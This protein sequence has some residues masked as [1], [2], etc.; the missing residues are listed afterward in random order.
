MEKGYRLIKCPGSTAQRCGQKIRLTITKANYGK[1]GTVT[2]PK[3]HLVFKTTIPEPA[4]RFAGKSAD[5][6]TD[7]S[8]A[9]INDAFEKAIKETETI[10]DDLLAKNGVRPRK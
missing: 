6:E 3:C 4:M 1:V 7:D 2:C 8:I 9:N 5:P 10:F